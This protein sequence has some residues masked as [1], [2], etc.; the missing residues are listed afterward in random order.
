MQVKGLNT[1]C[2]ICS[3]IFSYLWP[4]SPNLPALPSPLSDPGYFVM[5]SNQ[6]QLQT[7]FYDSGTKPSPHSKH[8]NLFFQQFSI[9]RIISKTISSGLLQI[10]IN[11]FSTF[12]MNY[13]LSTMLD[14][15]NIT[16]N[17]IDW[18]LIYWLIKEMGTKMTNCGRCQDRRG[19][20]EVVLV[21]PEYKKP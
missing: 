16:E 4:H 7:Y 12:V 17:V 15:R 11:L 9:W 14:T 6:V 10:L 21:Y 5:K 3:P 13:A 8:S 2:G 18:V 1:L 19:S 20:L